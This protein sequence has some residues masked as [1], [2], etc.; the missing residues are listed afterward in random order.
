MAATLGITRGGLELVTRLDKLLMSAIGIAGRSG[1]LQLRILASIACGIVFA[2]A[3]GL[4][5][6]ARSG[7]NDGLVYGFRL[8]PAAHGSAQPYEC[9][10]APA[11][12]TEMSGMFAFYRPSDTQSQ[13]DRERMQAYVA[14]LALAKSAVRQLSEQTL[15]A[16]E[17]RVAPEAVR[18]CILATARAWAEQ[19]AM[20]GRIDENSGLGRRQANLEIAWTSI[21]FA[22]AVAVADLIRP[23][24]PGEY[25][26]IRAWFDKLSN[27]LI[28]NFSARSRS[29]KDRWLNTRSNQWLWGAAAV[30]AMAIHLDDRDKLEWSL[31][32]L[33]AFLD[34]ARP[35]GGLSTELWRGGRALHYQNYALVAI[36]QLV[37]FARVNDIALDPARIDKL[38]AI[39]RF[40]DRAYRDPSALQAATDE[41]L[42]RSPGMLRWV[43]PM[44]VYFEEV[45]PELAETLA[46][47]EPP[48]ST[49]DDSSCTWVCL[50]IYS[51]PA[52]AEGP[53]Q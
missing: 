27:E 45:D 44:R 32:V 46:R 5:S 3:V 4:P 14:R 48:L 21:A 25:K 47:L 35:D 8:L 20:L 12:L 16:V 11:P 22:N 9:P 41:E 42:E 40:T 6:N 30:A 31:D 28:S 10:D 43:A 53:S 1:S 17:G 51:L 26:L 15:A 24:P 2:V 38:A 34:D 49:W 7:A 23:I 18:G 50:P 33:V 39:V 37:H 29:R 13:I 52:D 19:S 36:S